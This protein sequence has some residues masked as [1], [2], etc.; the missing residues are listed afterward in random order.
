MLLLSIDSINVISVLVSISMAIT[1]V[2]NLAVL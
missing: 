1:R 2:V